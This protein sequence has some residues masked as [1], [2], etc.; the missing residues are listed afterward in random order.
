[1]SKSRRSN[2]V[3][4]KL[5]LMKS[6]D[7]YPKAFKPY[8]KRV[9]LICESFM[10][11]IKAA[12]KRRLARIPNHAIL[13]H[14]TRKQLDAYELQLSQE[15]CEAED[16]TNKLY[17]TLMEDLTPDRLGWG[18]GP[19]DVRNRIDVANDYIKHASDAI[20]RGHVWIKEYEHYAYKDVINNS[21][22]HGEQTDREQQLAWAKHNREYIRKLYLSVRQRF[23]YVREKYRNRMMKLAI[24]EVASGNKPGRLTEQVL[25]M[26]DLLKI[27]IPAVDIVGPWWPRTPDIK[28]PMDYIDFTDRHSDIRILTSPDV[29]RGVTDRMSPSHDDW[30]FVIGLDGGDRE[31]RDA[32]FQYYLRHKAA[33]SVKWAQER[34]NQLEEERAKKEIEGQIPS[35]KLWLGYSETWLR[36]GRILVPILPGPE[37]KVLGP[38]DAKKLCETAKRDGLC[39]LD[40]ITSFVEG[41]D[42]DS[43]QQE[44]AA[45]MR[46]H[47]PRT[48]PYSEAMLEHCD[49]EGVCSL[50]FCTDPKRRTVVGLDANG[51]CTSE[52]HCT[53]VQNEVDTDAWKYFRK[54]HH[55]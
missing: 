49:D 48:S 22:Y 11:R 10:R 41:D 38:D 21:K 27:G 43:E 44:E 45:E 40:V 35:V 14:Y 34:S 51:I 37:W 24:A 46:K 16:G 52:H 4:Y 55:A 9:K 36:T 31:L 28:S 23:P 19:Y 47:D 33:P 39:V 13:K 53:G 6:W 15:A 8:Q 26:T 3:D 7:G 29:V 17:T 5:P 42:Y 32:C 12:Y 2:P 54:A 25:T 20:K 50:I 18:G 1:M 30:L